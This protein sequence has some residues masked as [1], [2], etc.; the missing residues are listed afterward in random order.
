MATYQISLRIGYFVRSFDGV[1]EDSER[2]P[3]SWF[4]EVN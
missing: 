2:F 4:P 3:S 1:E